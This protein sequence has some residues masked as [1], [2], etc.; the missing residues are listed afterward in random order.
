VENAFAKSQIA[1]GTKLPKGGL[2]F[3]SVK[4]DDKPAL[5][6]VAR[7]LRA[8]GFSLCATG[9]TADY[10]AK[11]NIKAERVRKVL[12]G[13][14]HVVDRI[15]NG[16]IA[17]V[18]NT[19]AGK[20]EIADSYSIRRESLMRGVAHFTTMEAARMVVG[21]LEAQAKGPREYR[22]LQEWLKPPALPVVGR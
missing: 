11:K 16:E 2:A 3:L 13:R 1:C 12:E 10:L 5:V 17:L 15:V 6:D 9:G 21:A 22:P 7:R 18:I 19:T 14:P 20:K 8:L 4:D